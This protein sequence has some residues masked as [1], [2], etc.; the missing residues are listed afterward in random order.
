MLH[1]SEE[2]WRPLKV[3]KLSFNT[4]RYDCNSNCNSNKIRK[5]RV[6]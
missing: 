2:L 4:P 3:I 5:G 6:G 1:K